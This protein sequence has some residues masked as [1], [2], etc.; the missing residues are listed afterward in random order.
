MCIVLP[1]L[2]W[3]QVH[4]FFLFGGLAL[5][6]MHKEVSKMHQ[7]IA[8]VLSLVS[9]P[10]SV[11]S[12]PLLPSVKSFEIPTRTIRPIVMLALFFVATVQCV[13]CVNMAYP[14]K[15]CWPPALDSGSNAPREILQ[16]KV[17]LFLEID[18]MLDYQLS[19]LFYWSVVVNFF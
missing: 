11:I 4:N 8:S 2:A 18:Y 14:H 5:R 16:S 6:Y 7:I 12:I 19:K 17:A 13:Y 15:S 3:M 1:S 10:L 9:A